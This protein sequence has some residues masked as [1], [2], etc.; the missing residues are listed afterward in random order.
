M[1]FFPSTQVLTDFFNH[2]WLVD[3]AD[4]PHPCLCDGRQVAPA[5]WEG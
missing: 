3:E 2:L 4:D 5:I 1:E